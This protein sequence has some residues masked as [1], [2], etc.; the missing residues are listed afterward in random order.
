MN[1]VR[2]AASGTAIIGFT[3]AL[4]ACGGGGGGSSGTATNSSAGVSITSANMQDVGAQGYYVASSMTTF[5]S[6]ANLVTG[7]AVDTASSSLVGVTI[8]GLYRAI[9]NANTTNLAVGGTISE[10]VPCADGGSMLVSLNIAS[11]STV[12]AGDSITTTANACN[13][14]GYTSNGTMSVTFKNIS[15]T[16]GASN[17][18]SGTLAASYT[19]FSVTSNATGN[20]ATT[21][22]DLTISFQQ[23]GSENISDSVTGNS[24]KLSTTQKGV[25]ST[26]TLSNFDFSR[27]VNANIVTYRS[28][29]SLNGSLNKVGNVNLTVKTLTD[30]QQSIASAFPTQGALKITA[31]DNSSVTLTVL[32]ST[33]VKLDLDKN[34]DGVIDESVTTT[35]TALQSR[36]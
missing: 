36:L 12:S 28:N 33:N 7:V 9:N 2:R 10:T 20:T 32:D 31:S 26:A 34:G 5:G 1:F 17:T 19:N 22:G 35:W 13:E 6:G 18:W 24:L 14:S 16:P 30:F 15:G 23:S 3:F 25:T 11:S 4:A 8:N 27:S 29:F 21:T